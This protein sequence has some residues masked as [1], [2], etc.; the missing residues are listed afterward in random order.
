[1]PREKGPSHIGLSPQRLGVVRGGIQYTL[2]RYASF[3][4][5]SSCGV[6]HSPLTRGL[7]CD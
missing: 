7:V 6:E 4:K 5:R 3:P 1:M 2:R